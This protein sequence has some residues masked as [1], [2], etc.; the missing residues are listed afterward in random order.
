MGT[1]NSTCEEFITP[2]DWNPQ[3]FHLPLASQAA[4]QLLGCEK[5]PGTMNWDGSTGTRGA[6]QGG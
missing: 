5:L 2:G 4:L 1:S 6:S 3:R